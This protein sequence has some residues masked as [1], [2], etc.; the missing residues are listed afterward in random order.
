MD[1]YSL[2]GIKLLLVSSLITLAIGFVANVNA[3]GLQQTQSKSF[4]KAV[5]HT[6]PVV[7][8]RTVVRTNPVIRQ[9]PVVRT[10]RPVLRAKAIAH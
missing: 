2:K 7:Y 3:A 5:G 8:A 6:N 9:K 10:T 1:N 4:T